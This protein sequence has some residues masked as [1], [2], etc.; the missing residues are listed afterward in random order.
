MTDQEKINS[1][2][3]LTKK[4]NKAKYLLGKYENLLEELQMQREKLAQEMPTSVFLEAWVILEK[5]REK[6]EEE[7]NG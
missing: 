1:Y 6:R 7:K 5:A 4:I 3:D 2:V